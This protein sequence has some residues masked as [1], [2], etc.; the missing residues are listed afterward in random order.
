M[1]YNY[2]IDKEALMQLLEDLQNGVVKEIYNIHLTTDG[3]C[4]ITTDKYSTII[5]ED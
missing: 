4:E 5:T 1:S 3:Y 2:K